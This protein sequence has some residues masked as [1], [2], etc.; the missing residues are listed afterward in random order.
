MAKRSKSLSKTNPVKKVEKSKVNITLPSVWALTRGA[1]KL[2]L[3]N[4]VIFLGVTIVYAILT[5]L[6]VGI[7]SNTDI[8]ALKQAFAGNSSISTGFNV[9]LNLLGTSSG[10]S[11]TASGA[12]QFI[13][14]IIASLA[15]IWAL[16]QVVSGV[17]IRIRDAYYRGMYALVP[18]ILILLVIGLQLLPLI[19]G[20]AI[21]AQV[22]SNGIAVLLFEKILWGILFGFSA[23]ISLYLLSSST[24]ALYIVTLPDMTPV[25]ALR[26]AHALVKGRRIVLIRKL[27]FLPLLL[28]VAAAIIMLPFILWMAFLAQAVFF[29]LGM[30]VLLIVHGYLFALY[31]GLINE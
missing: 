14:A 6:F 5:L 29:A 18:F 11:N 19:I 8:T 27:I 12:Y 10:S 20:S 30:F 7:A 24:F 4:R 13:L 23:L 25:K 3:Q 21:Y 22:M 9:F 1:T 26:S 16:R 17:K 31:R 15:I 2:I 28:F